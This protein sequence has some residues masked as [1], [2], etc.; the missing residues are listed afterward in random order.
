MYIAETYIIEMLAALIGLSYPFIFQIIARIDEKYH[1]ANLVTMFRSEG[2]FKWY[3]VLLVISVVLALI[4]PFTK[5]PYCS[6]EDFKFISLQSLTLT[7][8]IV[9]LFDLGLL[10][11]M[12]WIYYQPKSLHKRI[13]NKLKRRAFKYRKLIKNAELHIGFA[14]VFLRWIKKSKL[15]VPEHIINW[16]ISKPENSNKNLINIRNSVIPNDLYFACLSDLLKYTIGNGDTKL[17]LEVSTSFVWSITQCQIKDFEDN[18]SPIYYDDISYPGSITTTINNVVQECINQASLNPSLSHPADFLYYL[19]PHYHAAKLSKEIYSCIWF[20]LKKFESIGKDDWLYSFWAWI[21]QYVNFSEY[22]N[23]SNKSTDEINHIL[24]YLQEFSH[25]WFGYLLSRKRYG[26]IAYMRRHS[27][28]QPYKNLLVPLNFEQM[29]FF[30]QRIKSPF[31]WLK[32]V[33]D[34]NA[35]VDDRNITVFWTELYYVLSFILFPKVELKKVKRSYDVSEKHKV[36]TY[37]SFAKELLGLIENIGNNAIG[38]LNNSSYIL[39]DKEWGNLKTVFGFTKDNIDDIIIQLNE[40]ITHFEEQLNSIRDREEPSEDKIEDFKSQIKAYVMEGLRDLP[41]DKVESI[42][43]PKNLP[44]PMNNIN[45]DYFSIEPEIGYVNFPEALSSLYIRT[46]NDI[47]CKEFILNSPSASFVIDYREI[48]DA[49]TKLQLDSSFAILFLGSN[50]MGHEI[51]EVEPS[52]IF[53][54]P[55]RMGYILLMKA[56]YIP[57]ISIVEEQCISIEIINDPDVVNTKIIKG[58]FRYSLPDIFFRYIRIIPISTEYRGVISQLSKI[59]PASKY[60]V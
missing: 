24:S 26:M 10:L 40:I 55:S 59:Q 14:K 52:N 50:S 18:G 35:G 25:V 42:D 9:T 43:N 56:A 47:Y 39:D 6:D 7:I 34:Q 33:Y 5:N 58:E 4:I 32:Y 15:Q 41:L 53:H 27:N 22:A 11:R 19:F 31:N 13:D 17:Y 60:I 36:I 54:I 44:L 2:C 8:L 30:I 48:G 38:S 3:N 46:I 49:L 21:V 37:I 20:N 28:T 23:E 29:C 51:K 1:S 57:K 16:L 12:I 45:K